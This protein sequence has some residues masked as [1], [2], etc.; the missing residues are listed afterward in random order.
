MTLPKIL[1]SDDPTSPATVATASPDSLGLAIHAEY[2]ASAL[3][4]GVCW[5]NP[6]YYANAV[7]LFQV[8]IALGAVAALTRARF[9]WYGSLAIGGIGLAFFLWPIVLP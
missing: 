7:A 8:A 1:F 9:V 2:R 5:K 3:P 4:R 6:A